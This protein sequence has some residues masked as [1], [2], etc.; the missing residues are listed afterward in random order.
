MKFTLFILVIVS[1]VFC[2]EAKK[3]EAKQA[4]AQQQ[5]TA[6][7][8][9]GSV[10]SPQKVPNAA[11]P[12]KKAIITAASATTTTITEAPEPSTV[13][14][15]EEGVSYAETTQAEDGSSASGIV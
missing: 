9:L 8:S 13:A 3:V 6:A 5:E 11:K 4:Q 1:I 15:E 14:A 7:I 2:L 10:D 12:P